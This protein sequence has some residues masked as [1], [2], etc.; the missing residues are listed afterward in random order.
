MVVGSSNVDMI[1][2]MDHLPER[3]ETV[4][5]AEFLQVFGGKGANQ[6]VGAARAGGNVVFVNCVG[7]DAYTPQMLKNFEADGI[8]TRYVF[9]EKG[10]ASGH[11]LVMIGDAG[12]N[13]LSVAPGA[14]YRLT[15]E[16]LT[17][18]LPVFDQAAM[19]VMQYEIP[20]ETICRAIDEAN[21]RQLP[22]LMNFAPA[23]AFDFSYIKK[24]QYLVVNE[25][26]A[27]YLS[28]APVAN[29][30]DA[31][32][33][34]RTLQSKGIAHVIVTLGRQGAVAVG[35]GGEWHI[36]AFAV[37]TVDTTAAGDVFC[38]ALAVAMVEGKEL[39]QA[40]RFASAAAALTVMQLGA[41]SSIPQR[42]A[43]DDFLQRQP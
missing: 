4:T 15:P 16:R 13:Y 41:Q 14:N 32:H 2:K 36:P 40:M 1:M 18:A 8:D 37:D 9:R 23:R 27:A 30:Q 7:E 17:E 6:A 34:A 33:A 3:G 25:N 10:I 22:V 24:V 5:D 21:A 11:A 26:E 42:S 31:L 12:H 20:E 39:V 28:D 29:R 35:E 38:G 19:L 43:I